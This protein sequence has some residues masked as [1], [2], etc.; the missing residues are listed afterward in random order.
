MD[1]IIVGG[2]LKENSL[3]FNDEKPPTQ[4]HQLYSWDNTSVSLLSAFGIIC[5]ADKSLL[6]SKFNMFDIFQADGV[7]L[8][9]DP[10]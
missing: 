3:P 8:L 1:I 6:M 7:Q 9:E 4:N 5:V 2:F 10:G